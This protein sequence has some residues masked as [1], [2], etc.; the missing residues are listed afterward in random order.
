MAYTIGEVAKR[1]GLTT[2]TLRYYEKEG[3]LPEVKKDDRGVR[4]YEDTDLF[5]IELI[6][7]LKDTGMTIAEIKHI[8]D[9]SIE[10]EHT[11]PNRKAILYNHKEALEKEIEVLQQS[12]MK[13]NKKLD[14]YDG[15]MG[16]C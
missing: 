16:K 7:C 14:W 1:V 2:Y 12:I 11:I 13:I 9:L 3:L 15:K 8:V 6:K 10:G 5:W 4:V